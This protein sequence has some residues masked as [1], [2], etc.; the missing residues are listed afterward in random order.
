M[1][2]ARKASSGLLRTKMT[3][4][5]W[6]DGSGTN[7]LSSWLPDLC[8]PPSH[9]LRTMRLLR[10]SLTSTPFGQAESKS[11]RCHPS[12]STL[13]MSRSDHHPFASCLDLLPAYHSSIDMAPWRLLPC[14]PSHE[15]RASRPSSPRELI[16]LNPSVT[17]TTCMKNDVRIFTKRATDRPRH[18]W[19]H[20]ANGALP[21]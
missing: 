18:A 10:N 20:G 6:S 17:S 3:A 21:S 13:S 5:T 12:H 14:Q 19:F 11:H 9:S 7:T 2:S 4:P 1:S 15:E 16:I 8:C